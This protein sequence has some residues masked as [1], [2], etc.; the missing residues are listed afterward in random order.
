MHQPTEL[1]KKQKEIARLRKAVARLQELALKYRQSEVI[2][3]ALFKISELASSVTDMQQFYQSVHNIIGDLMVAKNFF[4]CLYDQTEDMVKFVYFVDEYDDIPSLEAI[5]AELLGKGLTGY[6]MRTGKPFLYDAQ[7]F[8]RLLKSGEIRDL[9]AAPVDWLGV[10][11]HS[12]NRV[13]GAMVV[14]SYTEDVRYS[15]A[16]KELFMFVSQHIVNYADHAR[17][18]ERDLR[19]KK[20]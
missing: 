7:I 5:P 1:V 18:E 15:E 13:I 4:I 2:Q 10:P 12:D 16:D 8:E 9:G 11:L 19:K 3:K 14:Q 6:V 20:K 17:S